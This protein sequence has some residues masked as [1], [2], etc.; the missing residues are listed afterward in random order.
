ML[1]I[2]N[3]GCEWVLDGE[4]VATVKF[5]GSCT[6]FDGENWWARREVKPGKTP[7]PNWQ[8]V[9]ADPATGKRMGW[10]PIEQS[11]FAEIFESAHRSAFPKVGATYELVGP[12][13]NG[14]SHCY[15]EHFLLRH[16]LDSL[17]GVPR[18]FEGLRDYL[19]AQP[20]PGMPAHIEGI[21][22]WRKEDDPT[23]GRAKIKVRDFRC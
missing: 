16:G 4:G 15:K 23:A 14:N 22:F 21:V 17:R 2:V 12:K 20:S 19:V 13:V 5:D 10:E 9:D 6:M 3:P 8:E 11:G 18:D 7:P 1:P